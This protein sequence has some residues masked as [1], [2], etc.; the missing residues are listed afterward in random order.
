MSIDGHQSIQR[1]FNK[2]RNLLVWNM[3]V[4]RKKL[5]HFSNSSFCNKIPTTKSN[6]YR[7]ETMYLSIKREA[8]PRF[9]DRAKA[10]H[11]KQL[12]ALQSVTK[13]VL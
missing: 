11:F 3:C 12:S 2:L 8:Q 9:H 4:Q 7:K 1:F 5:R 13:T 10:K 6:I